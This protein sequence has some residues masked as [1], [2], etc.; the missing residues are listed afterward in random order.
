MTDDKLLLVHELQVHQEEIQVQNQQLIAAQAALE[1]TRD[2]YIDLYDFAPNGY[3]TVDSNGVILQINLTGAAQLGKSREKL[4]G[5]PLL[6]FVTTGHRGEFLE[7]MRRCRTHNAGR[8]TG[9]MVELP[10]RTPDGDRDVQL[11]CRP[12]RMAGGRREYFMAMLDITERKLLEASQQAAAREQATLIER[13]MSAQEDERRSIARDIHDHLGQQ[14][15]GL[16][17]KLELL[18]QDAA[19]GSFA[20]RVREAQGIAED[21]D[22]HLDF[23]TGKLRPTSLDDLGLMVA[24]AQYVREWSANF[25][26]AAEFHSSGLNGDRMAPEVETHI[27]RFCQEALNNVYKHAGATRAG[28][29]LERRS[30]DVILIVEDNGHGFEAA[31]SANQRMRAAGL[32]L[33]G[34]RERAALV[35]G[36][37]EIESSPGRGTTVF[38]YLPW[39]AALQAPSVKTVV[40]ARGSRRRPQPHPRDTTRKT[41]TARSRR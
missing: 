10:M 5:L 13:L 32:G 39:K 12:R 40:A 25:K 36:R 37:L 6:A 11:L 1:E 17:L 15:T 16:R 20:A 18:A 19:G 24:L 21:L 2:L 38:L 9:P 7:F 30:H 28:V 23:F 3:L 41:A 8:E 35:G 29:I 26:I 14:V 27:Y 34:M 31:T 22:A 4:M 33:L